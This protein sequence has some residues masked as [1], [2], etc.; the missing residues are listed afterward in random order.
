SAIQQRLQQILCA[1]VE[2]FRQLADGNS[3][4][5]GDI[6]RRTWFRRRDYRGNGSAATCAR[7]LAR[8][9]KLALTFHLAL[10]RDG[11]LALRRFTCVQRLAGLRLWRHFVRQRRQHSGTS[12]HAWPWTRACWHRSAALLKRSC[13]SARTSGSTRPSWTRRKRTA[14]ASGS[15]TR[16]QRSDGLAGARPANLTTRCCAGNRSA[17]ASRHRARRSLR[18]G[19]VSTG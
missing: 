15:A 13:R 16:R 3:F 19:T 10:V 7:T 14:S 5:D 8:G 2:F 12:R 1:Y 18:T 9:V 4:G 11:P 17:I 6:A